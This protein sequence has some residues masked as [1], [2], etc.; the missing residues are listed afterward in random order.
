MFERF[1]IVLYLAADVWKEAVSEFFDDNLFP[2]GTGQETAP[3]SNVAS[4]A[5]SP[6]A[7]KT[8]Q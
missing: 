1:E 7:A 4:E 5:L 8:I 2:A 3:R 6:F